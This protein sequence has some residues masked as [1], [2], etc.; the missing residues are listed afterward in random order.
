MPI[1]AA[2]DWHSPEYGVCLP[3]GL[4]EVDLAADRAENATLRGLQFGLLV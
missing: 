1:D 4:Q 2:F 3:P